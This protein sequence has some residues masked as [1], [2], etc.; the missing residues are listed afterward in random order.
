MSSATNTMGVWAWKNRCNVLLSS[1]RY[2]RE[3]VARWDSRCT[4]KGLA[5]QTCMISRHTWRRALELNQSYRLRC[6]KTGTWTWWLRAVTT[7][8]TR[9]SWKQMDRCRTMVTLKTSC[10]PCASLIRTSQI[11][12]GI[13]VGRPHLA[14]CIVMKT[15]LALITMTRWKLPKQIL[16]SANALQLTLILRNSKKETF[17]QCWMVMTFTGTLRMK[18]KEMIISRGCWGIVTTMND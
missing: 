16:N 1:P 5:S 15:I 18:T 4:S 6:G 11:W 12:T 14:T 3:L 7:T 2:L 9:A 10:R 17:Q 13:Q 8:S